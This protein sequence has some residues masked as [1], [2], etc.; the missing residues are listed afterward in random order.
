MEFK[1]KFA[2]LCQK[3]PNAEV[4]FMVASDDM[5]DDYYTIAIHAREN[6]SRCYVD[7][8]TFYNDE[9]YLDRDGLRDRLVDYDIDFVME[10]LGCH[11]LS[12]NLSGNEL[13]DEEFE[14]ALEDYIDKN[15]TFETY[16]IVNV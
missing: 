2:E 3:Y 8:L 13:S 4:M 1:Q 12:H 9:M 5:N 6:K 10:E 11:P 16:I 7:K 15:Y 14:E